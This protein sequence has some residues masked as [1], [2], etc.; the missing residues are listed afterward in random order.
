MSDQKHTNDVTRT[1]RARL[2]QAHRDR[3]YAPG[4]EG[5]ERARSG[6]QSLSP[7]TPDAV[8]RATDTEDVRTAVR[9]AAELG[10]PVA[11]QRTG[12]GRGTGASGGILVDT[13]ALDTVEVDPRRRTARVGA[14]AI[15]RDV[16][17]AA[18]PHG[19]APLSGS[20]PAVG[21]VSYT[22]GGGMSL[23]GRRHGYAADHVHALDLVAADGETHRVTAETEPDLFW[24]LR[25][26]G[27]SFG[28]VTGMEFALFPV[29]HL[30]GGSLYLDAT[31]IPE[32]L[33]A[34]LRWTATVPEEMTSGACALVYPDVEGVPEPMRGRM[35]VQLSVAW[36]GPLAQGPTWVEPLRSIAPVLRDTTRVLPYAE[37]ETVFDDHDDPAPYRGR[38]MM[39]TDPG[40]DAMT[41]L[42]KLMAADRPFMSLVSL[43]H[44]GGAMSRPPKVPAAVSHRAATHALGVL[45]FATPHDTDAMADLRARAT[46]LLTEH[47]LGLASNLN[48]GP[49][50]T[51]DVAR[52]Y[53]PDALARLVAIR[54]RVDPHGRVHTNRPLT[55]RR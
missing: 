7:H 17:D 21:A 3:V 23:M 25:G 4:S 16:I 2:G 36:C 20:A 15:W 18:A 34:W 8:L 26:G 19:L 45:T 46:G 54:D 1:L 31:D 43:R 28:L 33:A 6:A 52:M 5:F 12:H 50:P 32:A 22:L 47:T 37:S 49:V 42:S 51:S 40:E 14:G 48:F 10:V 29:S 44:L 9:T 11:A 41:A 24:A 35:V 39:L 13:T 27:G 38:A 55:P 53:E 30:Y